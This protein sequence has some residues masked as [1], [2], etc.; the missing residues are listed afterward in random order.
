MKCFVHA[1]VEAMGVCKTC[2][3]GMC[4]ECSAYSG[5][6]GICPECRLEEFKK[7][8]PRKKQ[9]KKDCIWDIIIHSLMCIILVGIP[10][11]IEDIQELKTL[12]ERI[13][14]LEKEITRLEN[15]NSRNG[16]QV[17]K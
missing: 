16:T 10:R 7:E 8:L 14:V 15:V 1:N 9:N 12:N 4:A 13:E 3:K 6:T 17:F 11:L 5:H 2:G